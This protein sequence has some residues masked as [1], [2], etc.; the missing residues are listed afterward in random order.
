LLLVIVEKVYK[1]AKV[2][3]LKYTMMASQLSWL[4]PL[5]ANG[6]TSF[7]LRSTLPQY[8]GMHHQRAF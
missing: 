1:A 3:R 4:F 6:P 7:P 5:S 8:S 2:K